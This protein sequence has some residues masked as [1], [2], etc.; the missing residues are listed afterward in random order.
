MVEA[1][2]DSTEFDAQAFLVDNGIE[3]LGDRL[4][5]NHE[6]NMMPLAEAL[7]TC[8]PARQAIEGAVTMAR[9]FGADVK[10]AMTAYLDKLATPQT[11]SGHPSEAPAEAKKKD[12]KPS[13]AHR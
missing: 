10:T 6:G 13:P 7:A 8:A 11:R 1:A 9:E 3:S 4:V 2:P 5:A 12:L